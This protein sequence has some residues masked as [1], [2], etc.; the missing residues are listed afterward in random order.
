MEEVTETI[1]AFPQLHTHNSSRPVIIPGSDI[2][3]DSAYTRMTYHYGNAA[4]PTQSAIYGSFQPAVSATS[5]RPVPSQAFHA[6]SPPS[7]AIFIYGFIAII[8]L[9]SAYGQWVHY[10]LT[11]E[12]EDEPLEAELDKDTVAKIQAWVQIE[13]K[14]DRE[15]LARIKARAESKARATYEEKLAEEE[16][17]E[18]KRVSAGCKC[19]R[20]LAEE[21]LEESGKETP[22]YSTRKMDPLAAYVSISPAAQKLQR[23]RQQAVSAAYMEEYGE[24]LREKEAQEM[25]EAL[26]QR[27][28]YAVDA[29][30]DLMD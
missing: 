13:E 7:I 26:R 30:V 15:A 2:T 18:S 27:V 29:E 14:Q 11:G 16:Y 23:E 9:I 22:N 4:Q 25:G 8:I 17:E 6:A 1:T 21:D 19:D 3:P 10:I 28:A 5:H 20:E 12:V 24:K